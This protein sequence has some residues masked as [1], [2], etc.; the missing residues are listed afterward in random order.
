MAGRALPA[1]ERLAGEAEG[2]AVERGYFRGL[3]Q[4]GHAQD[5]LGR[6]GARRA[7][8]EEDELLPSA[9]SSGDG[10]TSIRAAQPTR[11]SR[12]GVLAFSSETRWTSSPGSWR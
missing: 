4:P 2:L 1:A 5:A 6:E 9:R 11:R 12:F 8:V 3:E 10:C 7:I